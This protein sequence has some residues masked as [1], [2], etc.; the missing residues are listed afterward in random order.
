MDSLLNVE[1]AAQFLKMSK[2]A[3]YVAVA[4][5]QLPVLRLGRRLRFRL[6]D[7][8]RHLEKGFSPT[9]EEVDIR[10]KAS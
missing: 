3:V 4:R 1:E 6:S 9:A 10:G 7:L 2:G 8:E 5:R